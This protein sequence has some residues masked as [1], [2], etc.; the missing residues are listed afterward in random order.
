MDEITKVKTFNFAVFTR[1]GSKSW[2]KK[3][4]APAIIPVREG[5]FGGMSQGKMRKRTPVFRQ[6]SFWKR[7]GID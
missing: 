5:A 7:G 6:R 1:K 2:I 4:K 3:G